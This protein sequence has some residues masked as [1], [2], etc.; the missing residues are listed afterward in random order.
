MAKTTATQ[1]AVRGWEGV[2]VQVPESWDIA[3][4]NGDRNQGYM[5]LDDQQNMPRV[6][7]KWQK[8]KGFVNVESVIDGYLKDLNKK[9]KRGEA[10]IEV[11]RNCSVV[12]KRRMRKRDLTCFAWQ[13]AIEGYGAGWYCEECE[14][15]MIVQVMALPEEDGMELA[16]QVIGEMEDHPRDGWLLWSTY[17]LTLEAPERFE[18]SEQKLMAGLIEFHLANAGEEIVAARWGM[19]NI[20][21]RSRSLERWA[22]SEIG[23]YHKSIKLSF[24]ETTFRGHPAVNVTGYFANPLRHLQSFVMH[25]LGKPYPEAVRGWVWHSEQENRIYYVGALF[26]EDNM[27]LIERVANSIACPEGD[28]DAPADSGEP[29]R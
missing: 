4:I 24:E 5:R 29:I 27:E 10:E 6:E 22:Q 1:W 13:G 20:A 8:A 7:I 25:I 17:G 11:D 19:A 28:A 23:Q 18:M 9:R 2:V 21:L 3:A 26:D 12:S 15:V 14:R 16:G